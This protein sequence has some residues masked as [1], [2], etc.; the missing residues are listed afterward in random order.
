M[1]D[2]HWEKKSELFSG[3]NKYFKAL[4]APTSKIKN[5]IEIFALRMSNQ[6]WQEYDKRDIFLNKINNFEYDQYL[7]TLNTLK[8]KEHLNKILGNIF[9]TKKKL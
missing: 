9:I 3:F 2:Y 5:F 6:S 4:I 7:N 8:Q 1:I